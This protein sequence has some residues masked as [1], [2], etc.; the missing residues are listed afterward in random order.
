MMR[1]NRASTAL[2]LGLA[3]YIVRELVKR[4]R[5]AKASARRLESDLKDKRFDITSVQALRDF[6]PATL[7]G[8]G[9]EDA[10]KVLDALDEQME[11][12]IQGSPF[13]MLA[14]AD[15]NGLPFCSPKGDAPGFVEVVHSR[16]ILLPVSLFHFC[17]WLLL[18]Y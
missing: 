10:P 6:L 15:R 5:L 18:L 8:T 11:G 2:L 12:F 14:T 9:M 1:H 17:S 13:C 7:S 3:L 16:K 4:M